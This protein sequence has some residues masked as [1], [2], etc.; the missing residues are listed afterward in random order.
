M[1]PEE[2][3]AAAAADSGRFE[4][5]FENS[6]NVLGKAAKQVH[7]ERQQREVRREVEHF[8]ISQLPP[9][10]PPPLPVQAKPYSS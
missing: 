2:A 4:N 10:P 8:T 5:D 9:P 6:S 1:L 3:V 7:R